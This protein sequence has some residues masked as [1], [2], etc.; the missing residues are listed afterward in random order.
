MGK[1]KLGVLLGGAYALGL[2]ILVVVALSLPCGTFSRVRARV[3]QRLERAVQVVR[4]AAHAGA[5]GVKHLPAV[6]GPQGATVHKKAVRYCVR[7]LDVGSLIRHCIVAEGAEDTTGPILVR[8][9]FT[10]DEG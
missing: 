10:P 9:F 2:A 8:T 7:Q 1:A 4:V 3:P 5:L 6:L